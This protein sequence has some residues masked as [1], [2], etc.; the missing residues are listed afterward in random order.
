MVGDRTMVDGT[1]PIVQ[2]EEG[3]EE[4][5]NLHGSTNHQR[6]CGY[7]LRNGMTALAGPQI[8][9]LLGFKAP[10]SIPLLLQTLH[11]GHLF[12]RL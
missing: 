12:P 9:L 8:V 5:A 11:D 6:C 10:S 4:R 3:E 7:V 2:S 1:Q